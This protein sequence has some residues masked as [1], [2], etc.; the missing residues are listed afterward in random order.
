MEVNAP[1]LSIIIINWHSREYLRDCL[2][3]IYEGDTGVRFEI[4]V[5]DNASYDG[6]EAVT[7]NYPNIIFIQSDNNLG[8]AKANN[9]AAKK[10]TGR[11]LLFLN[12]DT[13]VEKYSLFHMHRTL[14]ASESAAIAGPILLNGDKSIQTSCMLPFPTITRQLLDWDVI[15]KSNRIWKEI[16]KRE[17]GVK[18]VEA[19]S[20]AGLM[21]KRNVFE[22]ING[23]SECYFMYAEDID[24][25]Y[26]A[27]KLGYQTV[28]VPAA[29]ITHY[30]GG[31]SKKQYVKDF[32]YINQKQSTYLFMKQNYGTLYALLYKIVIAYAALGRMIL[33]PVY[34]FPTYKG[35]RGGFRKW[36]S[37]FR[38]AV[39]FRKF[40]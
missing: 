11:T 40:A 5:I 10:A 15:V 20:G 13:K 6:A 24:L 16:Q 22:S 25:C 23:F 8:F 38:W 19:V 28:L 30:G 36:S 1:E 3:S 33:M 37:I 31:S 12:P 29:E 4:I 27:R 32:V 21:I 7:Q 26:K 17:E 2:Q 34:F 35:I 9:L 39:G 14:W 18:K